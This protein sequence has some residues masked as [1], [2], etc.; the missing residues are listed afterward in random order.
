LVVGSLGQ[1]LV[2]GSPGQVSVVSGGPDIG[3]W[4]SRSS[5]SRTA[6]PWIVPP[7][8]SASLVAFRVTSSQRH[9][10]WLF[11]VQSPAVVNR[12]PPR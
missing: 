3:R 10:L 8:D 5:S 2:V 9:S 1:V 11:V 6:R 12:Q 4:L 7:T